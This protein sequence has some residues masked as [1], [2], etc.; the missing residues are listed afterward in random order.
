MSLSKKNLIFPV[1]LSGLFQLLLFCFISAVR[2]ESIETY[3]PLA[4][5]AFF[6]STFVFVYVE[7]CKGNVEGA[8]IFSQ[9]ISFGI[10]IQA[11]ISRPSISTYLIYIV[12]FG[13]AM[14]ILLQYNK[15]IAL[16]FEKQSNILKISTIFFTV[17]MVLLMLFLGKGPDGTRSWLYIGP[18]SIQL[19]EILKVSYIYFLFLCFNKEKS[20]CY[21]IDDKSLIKAFV[22]LGIYGVVFAISNEFG[23]LLTIGVTTYI[24]MF[25]YIEN[26]KNFHIITALIVVSLLAVLT[27]VRYIVINEIDISNQIFNKIVTRLGTFL[28]FEKMSADATYQILLSQKAISLGSFFGSS[29][30]YQK[31][32][33]EDTDMVFPYCIQRCGWLVGFILI[34]AYICLYIRTQKSLIYK[35]STKSI[36]SIMANLMLVFQ[37]FINIFASINLF[38]LSGIP[39][40][41][42]SSG[43]TWLVL[44]VALTTFMLKT[45]CRCDLPKKQKPSL[46]D[47]VDEFFDTGFV[48]GEE[49]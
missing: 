10:A 3:I 23:T 16:L 14:F 25:L 37:C 48:G 34:A 38:P 29:S 20:N 26:R 31:L 21:K 41:Y 42:I 13:T 36:F 40:N 9:L 1:V 43:G 19:T 33:N 11:S 5:L 30:N 4:G 6:F 2:P 39:L 44:S 7:K 32:I 24:A 12:A 45:T 35:P 15:L 47:L 8:F 17:I 22:L 49:K 18:I 28:A 46:D 27:V